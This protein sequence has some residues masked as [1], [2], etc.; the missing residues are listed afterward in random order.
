MQL[1]GDLDIF[2]LVR[3]IR[4]NWVGHI[5]RM[6]SAIKVSQVFNIISQRS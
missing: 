6:D 4:L 2:S 1:F 5:N 3:I